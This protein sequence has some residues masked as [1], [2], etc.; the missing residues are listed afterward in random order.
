MTRNLPP[1]EHDWYRDESGRVMQVILFDEDDESVE[2]QLFEGEITA[3]DL[4]SWYE[5]ELEPIEPPEDWSGPFDDLVNDDMGNTDKVMRPTDWNGP[6]DE[7][8]QED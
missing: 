6:A 3:F 2:V 5:L 1:R 4:Q 7:M 8:D